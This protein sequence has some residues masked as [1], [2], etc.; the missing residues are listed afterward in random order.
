MA[1]FY[2]SV[3]SCCPPSRLPS[4]PPS[5]PPF[6][7]TYLIPRRSNTLLF[8]FIATGEVV[9]K[10]F[11]LVRRDETSDPSAPVVDRLRAKPSAVMPEKREEGKEGRRGRRGEFVERQKQTQGE[12]KKRQRHFRLFP[13]LFANVPNYQLTYL[14]HS[15]LSP[16]RL[17]AR[18]SFRPRKPAATPTTSPA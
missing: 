2:F 3:L 16:P 4:L 14:E 1:C 13:L 9:S 8:S 18:G 10:A 12:G 5:L 7:P 17:G 15:Q 11:S 6:L